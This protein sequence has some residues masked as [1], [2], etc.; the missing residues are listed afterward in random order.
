MARITCS[1]PVRIEDVLWL[2][3]S[4]PSVR[5]R[6]FLAL[7]DTPQNR[8]GLELLVHVT[9]AG[10]EHRAVI[11]ANQLRQLADVRGVR[12]CERY[13]A[14]KAGI[15]VGTVLIL[16]AEVPQVATLRP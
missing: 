11:L 10:Y 7:S 1:P 5:G 13:G 8:P 12:W 9:L 2:K 15:R 16:Y 4:F 14:N 3:R 6:A